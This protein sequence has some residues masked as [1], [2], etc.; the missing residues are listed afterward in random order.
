MC[1]KYATWFSQSIDIDNNAG[2]V[3]TSINV[4]L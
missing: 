2:I 4:N 3:I 1:G